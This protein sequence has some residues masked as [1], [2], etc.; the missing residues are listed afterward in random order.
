MKRLPQIGVR[1][2][3]QNASVFLRAVRGGASYEVTSNGE[4]VA[5]LVP[6][7]HDDLE[8]LYREG[9]VRRPVAEGGWRGVGRSPARDRSLSDIL[10]E[11]RDQER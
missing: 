8:R 4:P 5:L 6:V 3:R 9:T 11:M 10:D 7:P 2:L 1:D